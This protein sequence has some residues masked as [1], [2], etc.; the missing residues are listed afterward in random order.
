MTVL[1]ALLGALR[2]H[3]PGPSKHANPAASRPRCRLVPHSLAANRLVLQPN[4]IDG[5]GKSGKIFWLCQ[6]DTNAVA[7]EDFWE[8]HSTCGDM[9]VVS[10]LDDD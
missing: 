2:A 3:D 5:A 10:T 6:A 1:K 8:F 4:L 9:V 7:A